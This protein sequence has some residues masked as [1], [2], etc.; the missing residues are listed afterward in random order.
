MPGTRG[1]TLNVRALRRDR[2][3]LGLQRRDILAHLPPRFG[4]QPQA[5]APIRPTTFSVVIGHGLQERLA[6]FRQVVAR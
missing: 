6:R 1:Y 2:P 4:Q 3:V 5:F